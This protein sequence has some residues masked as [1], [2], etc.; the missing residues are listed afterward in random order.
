VVTGYG[1]FANEQTFYVARLNNDGSFDATFAGGEGQFEH[2]IG[3]T[4]YSG[5]VVIMSDGRIVAAGGCTI[6]HPLAPPTIAG[7]IIRYQAD[8][9]LDPSFGDDG[10]ALVEGIDYASALAVQT[11][12]KVVVTGVDCNSCNTQ[13]A[14]TARVLPD[15]SLDSG[16]GIDGV[17][18][19]R[20]GINPTYSS[21]VLLNAAGN[22][23]VA[24]AY[25]PAT[26]EYY[27]YLV[28]L[29][30]DGSLDPTFGQAGELVYTATEKKVSIAAM[31]LQPDGKALL[32]GSRSPVSEL[33]HRHVF[34]LR[35][36][37]EPYVGIQEAQGDAY[38]VISADALGA[39]LV[40][41]TSGNMTYDVLDMLGRAVDSGRANVRAFERSQIT[42]AS[43]LRNGTY[44]IVLRD[45]G[46]TRSLRFVVTR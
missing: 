11:D 31:A 2:S 4:N 40:S 44:T 3:G 10:V 1:G 46:M 26:T 16:F 17:V 8:G 7:V 25:R 12:D 15:G 41:H 21:D 42:F 43:P 36:L 27:S 19:H 38:P 39:T 32:V 6:W 34:L 33:Y 18:T 22:I 24:G 20:S 13:W 28:R 45:G 14:R 23:M 5:E 30:D 35:Y 9:T 37:T 29:L